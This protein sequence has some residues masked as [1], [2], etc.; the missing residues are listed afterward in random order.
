MKLWFAHEFCEQYHE[1]EAHKIPLVTVDC[2]IKWKMLKY[3]TVYAL[4]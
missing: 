1:W 3:I 4:T 2:E